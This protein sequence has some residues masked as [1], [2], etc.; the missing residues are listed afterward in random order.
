M[1]ATVR[2]E[3]AG[4][5]TTAEHLRLRITQ[6]RDHLAAMIPADRGEAAVV[7]L[8]R[9]RDERDSTIR[10]GT[11]AAAPPDLITGHAVPDLGGNLALGLCLLAQLER[12][13]ATPAAIAELLPW[14]RRMLSTCDQLAAAELVLA[15]AEG[16]FMR[17]VHAKDDSFAA[18]IATNRTPTSWWERADFAW[19]AAWSRTEQAS[20]LAA[21]EARRQGGEPMG[22]SDWRQLARQLVAGMGYQLPYPAAAVLGGLPVRNYL[23]V[24]VGLLARALQVAH[25]GEPPA[26]QSERSLVMAL[27]APV[28]LAPEVVAQAIGAFALGV[29]A[30]AY[31]A[32]GPGIAAAPLV[33]VG[34]DRLVWSIHGLT[35]EP[36]LFLA[37]ELRRRDAE[38]YH[39]AAY[40]RETLFRQDLYS[41]FADR[42]FVTSAR[43]IELRRADGNARTD[44]DAVVFDRKTGTLGLF[45]LK[46]QDPFARSAAE[47]ARQRDNVLQANR[48]IAGALDWVKRHGAD[49]LLSRLDA[50]TAK[51]FRAQKVYPFVLG[52][53]LAHFSDGPPPDRRAAWG[54]WPQVLRLR[55]GRPC[56]ANEANPLGTLF[57]RLGKDEP[58]VRPP[59]DA[60]ARF[61]AAGNVQLTVYASFAAFQASE[62]RHEQGR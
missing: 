20:A 61:I 17:L 5:M 31:H 41:L 22:E 48:Q 12:L 29:D 46:S 39:N 24:L 1:A 60:P 11:T 23:A 47:Q 59:A 49:A 42:R 62:A 54:T 15:Q 34:E 9:A 7:A 2:R 40:Q 43:R 8:I 3:L 36:L 19:W 53:Y 27:A 51:R 56:G 50:P 14:A 13:P 16:G 33:R 45:E 6:E 26:P 57:T 55:D 32:T 10:P 35:S 44:L 52:R 4:S 25:R 30:A 58:P 21:L 18:W 28:G 37:R 38:A